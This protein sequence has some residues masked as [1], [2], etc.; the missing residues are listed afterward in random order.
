MKRWFA[1]A[2]FLLAGCA[3]TPPSQ[4]NYA[5]TGVGIGKESAERHRARIH[6][7]LG[8]GYYAQRQMAVALEEFSS[9][10]QIDPGYDQAYNGLGLVYASLRED[11]KA[12]A[13]F[14]KAVQLDPGNSESH[15]NYGTFLCS[16]DRLDE[17]IKEFLAALKNPLYPTPENAWVNAGI[18]S[19]KKGDDKSAETYLLNA[20]QIQPGMRNANYQL[21][22]L[23][24][25]KRGNNE[26]AN[27]YIQLALQDGDP[28]PEIVLL[29]LRIARAMGDHDAVASLDMLLRNRFPDSEQAKAAAGESAVK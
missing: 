13:N 9:A 27:K 25:N 8:A 19:M 21:A 24:F 3:G 4:D 5:G 29:G 2:I 14:R 18:C 10:V 20:V 23:Y 11:D 28:T 15:N 26:L 22:S 7:D 1:L 16:R 17:S 12:E 6:T